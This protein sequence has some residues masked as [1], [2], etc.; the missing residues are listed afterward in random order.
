MLCEKEGLV[1][2]YDYSNKEEYI[3]TLC[4]LSDYLK[5]IKT[6]TIGDYNFSKKFESPNSILNYYD[7]NS[8]SFELE[9][10]T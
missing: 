10:Q 3:V 1:L 5:D 4:E 2:V 8:H 7:E 6:S 9:N